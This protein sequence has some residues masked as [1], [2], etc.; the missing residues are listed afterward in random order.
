MGTVVGVSL[1]L[2]LDRFSY[3]SLFSVSNV[4]E[5]SSTLQYTSIDVH[6]SAD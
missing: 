2:K 5:V 6:N 3:V 4:T 1:L